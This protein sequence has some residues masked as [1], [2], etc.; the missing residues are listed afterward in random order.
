MLVESLQILEDDVARTLQGIQARR[1]AIDR[2]I[3]SLFRISETVWTEEPLS[4][5]TSR[6]LVRLFSDFFPEY[7]RWTEHVFGNLVEVFWAVCKRGGV[8]GRFD[9]RGATRLLTSKGHRRV[10]DGYVE[11]IRNGIAHGNVRFTGTHVEFGIVRPTRLVAVECLNTFDRLCRTSN[12]LALA[13][14]LF[15]IR[16]RTKAATV[17]QIPL[18]LVTRFAAG[19]VNRTGCRILGAIES[20]VALAGKQLHVAVEMNERNRA[21]V[22]LQ[23]ARIAA[24]FLNAGATGYNRVLCELDHG[25]AVTSLAII[26]PNALKALLDADASVDRLAEVFD[27]TQLLWFDESRWRTRLRAWRII[28]RSAA[29]RAGHQIVENWRNAG[30]WTGKGRFR[31]REVENVSVSG[32]ARV[33]LIA[34]LYEPSDAGNIPVVDE[35][36][37]ELVKVGRRRLVPSRTGNLDKGVRWLRRPA[38]VFVDLYRTDGPVRWL[39]SGGWVGGNLVAVAER[40]WGERKP[41]LVQ[42][43]ESVHRGIRIRYQIDAE[44]AGHAIEQVL[45]MRQDFRAQRSAQDT[46]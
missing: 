20:D 10:T 29:Q 45:R 22:L 1:K 23:S 17:G 43:P 12:A 27:E 5:G 42:N 41:V 38:H 16:H 7:L 25:E 19:A 11:D 15:W 21:H 3:D 35:I 34:V 18:S 2:G 32:I 31:I 33:R 37:R 46:S 24:H 14:T 39:R 36:L 8:D 40:T 13:L 26:K 30:L 4:G 44:A 6:T 28:F 9:L